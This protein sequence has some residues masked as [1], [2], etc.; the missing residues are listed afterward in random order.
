MTETY[1]YRPIVKPLRALVAAF[2]LLQSGRLDA[3]LFYMVIALVAV[4]AIAI[5]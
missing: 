4:I 1:L 5:R 2:L 3:Y